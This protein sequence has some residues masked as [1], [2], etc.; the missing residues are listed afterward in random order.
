MIA[1]LLRHKTGKG[2]ARQSVDYQIYSSFAHDNR[3][4]SGN[5]YRSNKNTAEFICDLLRNQRPYRTVNICRRLQVC[6]HQKEGAAQQEI[7]DT[8]SY[9]RKRHFQIQI[10]R[11]TDDCYSKAEPRTGQQKSLEKILF[12][13][14]K[15]RLKI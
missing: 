4:R 11:K 14:Y 3:N 1:S 5:I 7:Q 15:K 8:E 2:Q 13:V 9:H 12:S 6:T 10:H